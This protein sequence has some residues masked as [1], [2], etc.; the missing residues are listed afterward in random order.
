MTEQKSFYGW[1]LL[2]ILCLVMFANNGFTQ[3][4]PSVITAYMASDM[5]LSRTSLGLS[6]AA[7][8][9]TMGLP[10]PLVALSIHRLGVRF[11]LCLGSVLM[12]LGSLLLATWVKTD[13]QMVIVFGFVFGAGIICGGPPAASACMTRWFFKRRALAM[14]L[15]LTGGS[16]GSFVAPVLLTHLIQTSHGNWRIG[17][18]LIFGLCVFAGLLTL[19]CVK[20]TPAT[21]GQ[22]PDGSREA[23]NSAGLP[24]APPSIGKIHRTVE[25][26]SLGEVLGTSMFWGIAVA[27]CGFGSV[28]MLFLAHGVVHLRDLGRS[29][30]EAATLLTFLAIA[31]LLGTLLVAAIGDHLEPRLLLVVAVLSSGAGMLLFIGST[32]STGLHLS[33]VLVGFGFGCSLPSMLAVVANSYGWQAFPPVTGLLTAFEF[34]AGAAASYAAGYQFDHHG[35]YASVFYSVSALCLLGAT[36]LL[37]QR[38]PVKTSRR[39]ALSATTV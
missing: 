19:L 11:T 15:L 29:P 12:C 24:Q 26:W 35:S 13:I 4:G 14:S 7:F 1:T 8:Q 6:F 9:W 37:F 30:E 32:A 21:M 10:G 2:G 17:W 27:A 33:A 16:I 34:T 5:H 20:E 36:V 25:V 18:W 3:M 31:N 22:Q 28:F 38:P 39:I 23:V